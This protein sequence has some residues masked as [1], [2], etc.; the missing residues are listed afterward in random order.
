MFRRASMPIRAALLG[1][2][3]VAGLS[4]Y[5]GAAVAAPTLHGTYTTPTAH[6]TLSY[7]AVRAFRGGSEGNWVVGGKRYPGS[8][9]NAVGGGTGMAWYFGTSGMTAGNALVK[10]QPDGTYSGP[11]WFFNRAGATTD[12]GTVTI[13]F[14]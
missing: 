2:A 12:T 5:A 10:L 1:V 4:L 11:V 14:P 3:M 8:L 13:T 7:T 9:Y 6:G